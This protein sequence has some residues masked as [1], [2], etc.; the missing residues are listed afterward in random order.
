MSQ[1]PNRFDPLFCKV[2]LFL[3]PLLIVGNTAF[4]STAVLGYST[5]IGGNNSDQINAMQVDQDGYVYIAGTTYSANY[6]VTPGAFMTTSK[7]GQNCGIG[8]CV[9]GFITKLNP[10]GTQLVYSTFFPEPIISM[11]LDANGNVFVTG[12]ILDTNYST[13]AGALDNPNGKIFVAK[14]NASGSSLSYAARFGSTGVDDV[15]AIAVDGSG[16]TYVAGW[17]YATDYPVTPGAFATPQ[18]GAFVTELNDTGSA[19]VYSA[20][21]GGSDRYPIGGLGTRPLAIAV[22]DAHEAFV[23]G[24]TDSKLFPVTATAFQPKLA[25]GADAFLLRLNGSGSAVIYATYLGGGSGAYGTDAL[26][27]ANAVSV[28]QN[29]NAYLT[30]TARSSTHP[31]PVTSGAFQKVY[32]PYSSFFAF[33]ARFN[34]NSSGAASLVYST[35]LGGR[36]LGGN[37]LKIDATGNAYVAGST[38]D[39][40][41]PTTPTAFQS[42]R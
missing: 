10:A 1:P 21:L 32:V 9:A 30:G 42:C 34:T 31:F 8:S 22:N 40:V 24:A 6:P 14:L 37:A 16:D 7:A 5:Y 39:L 4:A 3:F 11:A 28:D 33:V 2:I 35:L 36:G 18:T 15:S 13:T 17:S 20:R 23:T 27:A 25:G 19:F 26:E 29:G 41:F 38:Y 12:Q